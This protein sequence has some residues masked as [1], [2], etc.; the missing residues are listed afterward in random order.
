MA[1]VLVDSDV[2]LDIFTNDLAWASWSA[3]ALE[4]VA[5]ES[6]LAINPIICGEVS[7]HFETIEELDAA[8]PDLFVERLEL[9]WDA[10]FP[11]GRCFLAYRRAGGTR[12]APLPDFYIGAHAAVEG[13]Q[14]LTRDA[15]RYRS[16]FPKL[17]ILAP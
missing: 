3:D 13:M 12:S 2:L 7:L 6:L 9:P 14:L 1:T 11:A 8:L 16:Y 10:A 17:A 15:S 4:R 5:E